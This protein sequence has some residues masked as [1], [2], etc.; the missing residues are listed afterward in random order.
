MDTWFFDLGNDIIESVNLKDDH[1][2]QIK[3]KNKF[4]N[5]IDYIKLKVPWEKK[6]LDFFEN[7]EKVVYWSYN[8]YVIP[9][10]NPFTQKQDIYVADYY[11]IYQL[12]PK[13][14][15]CSVLLYEIPSPDGINKFVDVM[16]PTTEEY[17][18]LSDADKFN[19]EKTMMR[20]KIETE[21]LRT[22]QEHCSKNNI[23][24][25]ILDSDKLL[26]INSFNEKIN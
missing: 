11:A 10:N 15:Q 7:D 17:I 16:V 18:K 19:L 6:I 13:S 9:F 4:G 22:I 14:E 26:S 2:H 3:D 8:D 25:Y 23:H 12:D 5:K 21:R 20:N 24:F 1:Y